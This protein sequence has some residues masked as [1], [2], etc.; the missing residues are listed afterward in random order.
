MPYSAAVKT[1]LETNG[2]EQFLKD[3]CVMAKAGGG[4][5]TATQNADPTQN[6]KVKDV[7]GGIGVKPAHG[8]QVQTEF[9]PPQLHA[10][11]EAA[12]PN[13]NALRIFK[14]RVTVYFDDQANMN[15][16]AG[17]PCY[18]VPSAGDT[19][20]GV[21]VPVYHHGDPQ[22]IFTTTQDGCTFQMSGLQTEPFVSHT[23]A[24][25]NVGGQPKGTILANRIA[26]L[27]AAFI[28]GGAVAGDV[29]LD[30]SQFALHPNTGDQSQK[31]QSEAA[32]RRG[33]QAQDLQVTDH[34]IG[35]TLSYWKVDQQSVNVING[36][37]KPATSLIIGQVNPV[38]GRWAFYYQECGDLHV[39]KVEKTKVAFIRVGRTAQ[40]FAGTV[41]FVAGKFWPG[42]I[43]ET[44]FP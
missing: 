15:G 6:K 32:L 5:S 36:Q 30:V 23:N 24:F 26:Q 19:A 20:V 31:D 16:V 43:T 44:P 9:H 25:T 37:W 39:K 8:P 4:H 33:R 7:T 27:R 3:Y 17:L 42:P 18:V 22:F 10:Y 40:A 34:T 13:T 14:E 11:F 28:T 1:A 35:R 12:P 41:V 21:K 2:A 29:D 38:N